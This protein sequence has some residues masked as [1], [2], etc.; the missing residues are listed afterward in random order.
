MAAEKIKSGKAIKVSRELYA[1]LTELKARG[2]GYDGLLRR[3]FGIP[4][5]NG[6]EQPLRTYFII[7]TADDLI[8][9]RTLAEARGDA[10]I[11]A[12]KRGQRMTDRKR[13]ESVVKVRELP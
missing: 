12:V 3:H 5:R 4:S 7:D 8:V 13:K 1:H 6:H 11:L 2:E 10:I 9:R